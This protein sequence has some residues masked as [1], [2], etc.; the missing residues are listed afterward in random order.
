MA[1]QFRFEHDA[2]SQL[3]EGVDTLANTVG[4]TLGPLGRNV[5][6]DQEFGAPRVCSDGVTI[7]KEIE[8]KEPFQNMGAQLLKEAASKTN[9]AVGDGT[10]TSTILAQAILHEGFKNVAAGADPMALK[11][12][13]DKAVHSLKEAIGTMAQ[14]INTRDQI[15]QVATLAG[16]DE[17]MGELL[18]GV[19]HEVGSDGIVSIEES[20]GLTYEVE[21]VEGMEIDRGYL[22]PYL[23]TNPEKM[24]AELEDPQILITS[25]KMSS[26]SELM[27]LLEKIASISRN[28][29]II[30][31]DVEGEVLSTLVV[32]K[33]RGN[34]NC[35]AVKAPAFGDR[36][37]AILEDLAVLLGATVISKDTGQSLETAEVSALG[38]CRRVIATKDDTTFVEG[39]GDQV[40]IEA[41]VKQ[42]KAQ[43]EDTKSDYDRE[44]LEERAAK[45]SGGVAVVRVGAA[46]EVELREKKQRLDDA[47]HATRAAMEEGIVAGGRNGIGSSGPG[48][49]G[50]D[51]GKWG[52]DGRGKPGARRRR[53]ACEAD[54]QQRRIWWRGRAGQCQG[55]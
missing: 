5:L 11:R 49:T 50:E 30:A 47:L 3:L 45:L 37:K 36:R 31:E 10:T 51:S 16:H 9:D 26:L 13:M 20:R 38:L 40:L 14:P 55:W 15:A 52:R 48:H 42:I 7:A 29:L 35:L 54:C 6:L 23:V 32:N 44:K 17:E 39:G 1:K 27:P 43:A 46:T 53:R 34:L 28:L 21:H 41:R 8:L 19:L 12:G 4:I 2:R 25:E 22:S 18:A 24:I 33:I